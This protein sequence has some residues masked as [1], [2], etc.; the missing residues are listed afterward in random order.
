MR[1]FQ[2]YLELNGREIF[3][4]LGQMVFIRE[5]LPYNE[6]V[7]V[8]ELGEEIYFVHESSLNQ[9]NLNKN[10]KQKSTAETD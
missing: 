1:Q 4:Y 7:L 3:E 5:Y 9:L 10:A 8:T 2:F 6:V